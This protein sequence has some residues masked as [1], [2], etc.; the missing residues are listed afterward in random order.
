MRLLVVSGP[1][2][3]AQQRGEEGDGL[4]RLPQAYTRGWR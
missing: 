2:G 3:F 4:D 1:P